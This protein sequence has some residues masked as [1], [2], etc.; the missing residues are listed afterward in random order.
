M[1]TI[2]PWSGGRGKEE[3]RVWVLLIN[4]P[5]CLDGECGDGKGYPTSL[6]MGNTKWC[7]KAVKLLCIPAVSISKE[8]NKNV[9]E[10]EIPAP[11][12]LPSSL[13]SLGIWKGFHSTSAPLS[14][15]RVPPCCRVG[16]LRLRQLRAWA[17]VSLC[18]KPKHDTDSWVLITRGPITIKCR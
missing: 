13:T 14:Y 15:W 17:A 3:W 12:A 7:G 8:G 11:F 5:L 6:G 10:M 2:Q 1:N 18:S 16:S 9:Q 4:T